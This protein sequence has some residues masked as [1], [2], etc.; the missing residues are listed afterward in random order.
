MMGQEETIRLLQECDAGV[1]FWDAGV[2]LSAFLL[3]DFSVVLCCSL[4][5]EM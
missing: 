5:Q 1:C 2:D 3:E 4:I